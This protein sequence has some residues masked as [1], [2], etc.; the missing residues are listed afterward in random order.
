MG[1]IWKI[2]GPEED[3]LS[4]L[5]LAQLLDYDS[6][7]TV[8]RLVAEGRLPPPRGYGAAQYYTGLDVAIILEMFGRWA[9]VKTD[10]KPQR[11]AKGDKKQQEP[12][13]ED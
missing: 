3:K 6:P 10:E 8:R 1:R 13:S 2:N 4:L 11:P 9:P 7:D 12:E 5:Q